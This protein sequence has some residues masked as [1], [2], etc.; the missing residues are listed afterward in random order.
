MFVFPISLLFRIC[1]RGILF[2]RQS[3]GGKKARIWIR[4]CSAACA[5]QCSVHA[6]TFWIE[7]EWSGGGSSNSQKKI[8]MHFKCTEC[9]ALHIFYTADIH[10]LYLGMNEF[11]W[12]NGWFAKCHCYRQKA[13]NFL[14]LFCICVC[15]VIV[16]YSTS[17]FASLAFFLFS[18]KT[19]ACNTIPA[20][21]NWK[22]RTEIK[23]SSEQ[24]KKKS[25]K[26][27]RWQC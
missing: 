12:T 20:K 8:M 25:E 10:A 14:L 16:V 2:R 7:L 9:T 11:M 13:M 22:Q 21:T 5:V 26:H 23:W 15:C 27:N 6:I 1:S 24:S 19:V 18:E 17:S 4:H 3:G